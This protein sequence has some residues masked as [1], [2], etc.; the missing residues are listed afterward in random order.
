MMKKSIFLLVVV[1]FSFFWCSQV[2]LNPDKASNDLQEK[3][4]KAAKEEYRYRLLS[5]EVGTIISA[6]TAHYNVKLQKCFILLKETIRPKNKGK[7]VF[8]EYL[9]DV[10]EN[11]SCGSFFRVGRG[12]EP[13]ECRVDTVA[14]NSQVDW[15]LLIKPYLEQ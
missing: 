2:R 7:P 10:D 15:Y 9:V 14:C 5:E 1:A 13:L 8:I 11:K 4:Q 6:Y 12:T 3:C